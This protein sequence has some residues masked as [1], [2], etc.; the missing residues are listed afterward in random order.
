MTAFISTSF[1][2]ENELECLLPL[3]LTAAR[4][5]WVPDLLTNLHSDAT[6]ELAPRKQ[7]WRNSL[8]NEARKGVN[9][10]EESGLVAEIRFGRKAIEGP[11]YKLHLLAMKRL[12]V[13]PHPE[14]FFTVLVRAL[15]ERLVAAWV[16]HRAEPAAILLGA[17]SGQ[18]T[19]MFVTASNPQ[20]LVHAAE[21][22]G[23]LGT[24]MKWASAHGMRF[25]DFGPARYPGQIQFKK[26]WGVRL[27]E[28][29][30]YLIG[31]AGCAETKNVPTVESSCPFMLA[32]ATLWRSLVPVWLTEPLGPPIRKFLTK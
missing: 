20:Y 12:G 6:L 28:Y 2:Q 5:I 27:H 29:A 13:P 9:R 24:H 31:P 32:M 19:R 1:H 10:A 14:R 30:Y 22:F 23:P 3:W 8:T 4:V 21:W 7:L 16:L 15:G 26:K 25:F 18:R 17:F 11:F